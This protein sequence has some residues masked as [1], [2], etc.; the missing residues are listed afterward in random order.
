[1]KKLILIA[2]FIACSV[3]AGAQAR[4]IG[5]SGTVY[6][7]ERI[8]VKGDT[9]DS[10]GVSLYDLKYQP[11][12]GANI[13]YENTFGGANIMFEGSFSTGKLNERIDDEHYYVWDNPDFSKYTSFS[14]MFLPGF[15]FLPQRR[16][17]IPVNLGIGYD[18]ITSGP[19]KANQAVI[20]AK[21]RLKVYITD[22]FGIYAGGN[23]RA[24]LG[25]QNIE[26]YKVQINSNRL[27]AD[28]GLTYTF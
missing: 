22:K 24:G 10:K 21:I 15:T 2:A 14:L 8:K 11:T 20:G 4:N 7:R 27:Y 3:I 1:M 12:F 13:F 23:W 9:N 16:V 18:R 6:G 26:D 5:A 17:Q 28:V 19:V 25:F